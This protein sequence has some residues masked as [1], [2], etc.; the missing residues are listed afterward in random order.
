MQRKVSE[1]RNGEA[2]F[3]EQIEALPI[4]SAVTQ[5]E[6]QLRENCRCRVLHRSYGI[7]VCDDRNRLTSTLACPIS[8]GVKKP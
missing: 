2:I 1:I 4:S 5:L 3:E 6:I 8:N 7:I